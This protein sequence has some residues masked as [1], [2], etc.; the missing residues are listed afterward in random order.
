MSKIKQLILKA[1]FIIIVYYFFSRAH[2]EIQYASDLNSKKCPK[3][4][5][6]VDGANSL[7]LLTEMCCWNKQ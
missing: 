4:L 7:T 5:S 1:N 2:L 6:G 3:W